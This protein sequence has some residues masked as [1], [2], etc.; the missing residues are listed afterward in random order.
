MEGEEVG[1]ERWRVMRWGVRDGGDEGVG[2]N[3]M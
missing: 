3:D 2:V 1:G